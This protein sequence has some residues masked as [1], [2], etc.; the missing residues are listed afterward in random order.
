[1]SSLNNYWRIP[2][3]CDLP[4]LSEHKVRICIQDSGVI[5]PELRYWRWTAEG[6][7]ALTEFN[8]EPQ[9][10]FTISIRT[11]SSR[12]VAQTIPTMITSWLPPRISGLRA[13]GVT[14]AWERRAMTEP[15]HSR[16]ELGASPV[17]CQAAT[18][19]SGRRRRRPA[20]TPHGSTGTPA[21]PF[22]LRTSL[23]PPLFH[24]KYR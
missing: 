10:I 9:A 14:N 6:A 2:Q 3:S 11:G 19:T 22:R 12:M 20:F 23:C 16:E 8:R 4:Y 7:V 21:H 1:M 13:T 15:Q 5:T 18:A 17:L 24:L